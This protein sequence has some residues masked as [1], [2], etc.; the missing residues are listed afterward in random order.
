MKKAK[1]KLK[2]II[3]PIILFIIAVIT[4]ICIITIP[5]NKSQNN[6]SESLSKE[7]LLE[8]AKDYTGIDDTGAN[9]TNLYFL[10]LAENMSNAESQKGNIYKVEGIVD[11]IADDHCDFNYGVVKVRIYLPTDVL[12]NFKEQETNISIVGK[13]EDIKFEQEMMSDIAHNDITVF[14]LKNCYLIEE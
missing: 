12:K 11:N 14:E 3:I 4:I 10:Q 7:K 6:H 2:V 5:K 1:K 13:L 9:K 8:T